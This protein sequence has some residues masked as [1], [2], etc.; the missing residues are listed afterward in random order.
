MRLQSITGIESNFKSI[1]K[2][3]MKNSKS[4]LQVVAVTHPGQ[5]DFLETLSLT[6]DG[7]ELKL[8]LEDW[9]ELQETL[10]CK[11][12]VLMS[13]KMMGY[14]PETIIVFNN[15]NKNE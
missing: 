1:H 6:K 14:N 10:H 12:Q 13:E 15:P 8:T 11:R 5:I 3:K 4:S 7:I 9:K 2:Y